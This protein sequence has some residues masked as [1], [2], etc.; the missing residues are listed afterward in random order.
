MPK[1]VKGVNSGSVNRRAE[2][3]L[4]K[5]FLH[6]DECA[7][8]M[9]KYRQNIQFVKPHMVST[10]WLDASSPFTSPM[11]PI[12]PSNHGI[13]VS[14][15]AASLRHRVFHDSSLRISPLRPSIR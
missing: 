6:G 9:V 7:I 13:T 15:R 11:K 10:I 5:W 2:T 3:V 12:Q 4:T 8:E 14:K 1:Q